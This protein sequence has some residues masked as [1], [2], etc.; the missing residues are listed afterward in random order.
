M[1]NI[2]ILLA[3]DD[4]DDRLFFG[5]ALE[6]LELNISLNWVVNGVDLINYLKQPDTQLPEL[7]F[8]DLNMPLKGGIEC[9][10][11]IRKTNYLRNLSVA[12][13]STSSAEKDIEECL[14]HGANIYIKKPSDFNVLKSILHKAITINHQYHSSGLSKENFLMV[15]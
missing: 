5:E 10:I 8:L 1:K 2:N 4:D 14:I 13:Y 6:Q 15:I 11:E 12:I 3:D 9:L 7:L